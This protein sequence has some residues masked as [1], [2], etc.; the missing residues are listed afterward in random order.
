MCCQQLRVWEAQDSRVGAVLE[1]LVAHLP[2]LI[3][4]QQGLASPRVYKERKLWCTACI[5]IDLQML[6]EHANN[7][8]WAAVHDCSGL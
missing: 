5:N 6:W 8:L 4:R 2:I 3:L 7:L 1:Q